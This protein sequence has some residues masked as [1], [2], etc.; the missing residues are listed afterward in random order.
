MRL[1]RKLKKKL[2]KERWKHFLEN[3]EEII[4]KMVFDI[5]MDD[6]RKYNPYQK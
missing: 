3:H 4:S 6:L 1:P 2:Q 5:M